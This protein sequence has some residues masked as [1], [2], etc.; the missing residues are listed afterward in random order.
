MKLEIENRCF[1]T[2][3]HHKISEEALLGVGKTGP[4][5]SSQPQ[6]L[7]FASRAGKTLSRAQS[8]QLGVSCPEQ[9]PDISLSRGL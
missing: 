8:R 5:S 3:W 6:G 1:R 4:G 7:D 2:P 9:T